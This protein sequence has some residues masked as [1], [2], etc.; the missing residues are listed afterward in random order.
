MAT[1]SSNPLD[2][3]APPSVNPLDALAPPDPHFKEKI[4]NWDAYNREHVPGSPQWN[5]KYGPLA[6]VDL[7][8]RAA[9]GAG[10]LYTDFG[11]GGQQSDVQTPPMDIKGARVT[12][13][14]GDPN[15]VHEYFT[16]QTAEEK[17]ATDEPLR[18]SP[19]ATVGQ[20]AAALP[21]AFLPGANAAPGAAVLGAGL[22]ALQPTIPGE[23]RTKNAVLGAALGTVAQGVGN[24]VGGWV[25]QRAAQP[26]M[27]WNP[28]TA[29]Q[30]AAQSVGSTAPRLT[31]DA[32]EET[33]RRLGGIFNRARSPDVSVPVGDSTLNFLDSA[34]QGLNDSSRS[35]LY[36]T[37]PVKDLVAHLGSNPS[38]AQ[39]GQI[40]SQLGS[41]ARSA[42]TTKGGD[43]ALGRTLF[44]VQDHV[45]GLVGSSITDPA[46]QSAYTAA[47]PQYRNFLTLRNRPTLLNSATG[48]VN[49]TALGRYLQRA[50]PAGYAQ[51]RNT[52]PLYQAGRW[53][54]ATK[55]GGG[56]PPIT[57][58]NLGIPAAKYAAVNNPLSR[59]L[60]GTVS[61]IGAP[62]APYL[63]R[64]AEGAAVPAQAPAQVKL[65]QALSILRNS[66]QQQPP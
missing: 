34:S 26:F 11:L 31:Q 49:A 16:G 23:S 30:A 36:A 28:G 5:E 24:K 66:Q 33:S 51:G 18:A 39:L 50:D 40:S 63:G 14:G 4:T 17:R 52:S 55:Q 19:A 29:S 13:V 37:T 7:I 54:Q 45:D 53:G 44:N 20:A 58:E 62:V 27:G 65:A 21:L 64:V 6:G 2:D 61:R 60:A 48:E 32:L 59:A 43:R 42:L 38:A 10:K 57:L 46:L 15:K 8:D 47:L 25:Q 56:A 3:L 22:G 9:M 1:Q 12:S 35:A 41:E